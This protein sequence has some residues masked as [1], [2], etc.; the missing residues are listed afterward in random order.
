[1]P[2]PLNWFQPIM[3]G[4]F[5]PTRDHRHNTYAALRS[6]LHLLKSW[7]AHWRQ[8]SGIRF[9]HTMKLYSPLLSTA[10]QVLLD[11]DA[12]T[13]H[14][15]H[16]QC[17]ILQNNASCLQ[18]VSANQA[19]NYMILGH[20]NC[21]DV[22]L[23]YCQYQFFSIMNKWLLATRVQH[24]TPFNYMSQVSKVVANGSRSKVVFS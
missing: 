8:R 14:V 13:N 15:I 11:S 23:I 4:L 10:H 1:M 19:N 21:I 5:Q 6:H 17:W 7:V 3:G 9:F 2:K 16:D 24:I 20:G 22:R 18:L 12:E